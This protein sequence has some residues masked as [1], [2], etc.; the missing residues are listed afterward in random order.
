MQGSRYRQA[1]RAASN[2]NIFSRWAA[3]LLFPALVLFGTTALASPALAGDGSSQLSLP[4]ATGET[5]SMWGGPHPWSGNNG[6]FSSLDFS[7]SSGVVRAAGDGVV[8]FRACGGVAGHYLLMI[9]HGGVWHT[10]YYHIINVAVHDG[11]TVTRGTALGNIGTA[12]PCG[13]SANGA[14]V[15]FTVWNF[16]G[17]FTWQN[18]QG[19]TLNGMD[20]G[21]WT[22]SAGSTAYTGYLQR[23]SDGQRV[24]RYGAVYNNGAIGSGAAPIP[25]PIPKPAPVPLVGDLN[26]D[27]KVDC[28]DVSIMNDSFIVYSTPASAKYPHT[29][30]LNHDGKV[31]VFDLSILLSHWDPSIPEGC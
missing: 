11:Q 3:I 21:G 18:A 1:A 25:V 29:E 13:G 2:R 28:T 6:T 12:T 9:D 31:D 10:S 22:A 19:A 14:H 5:W 26:H 4:F 17:A 20:I 8:R 15:H 7:G 27:G 16:T 30:D 23:V 24:Q